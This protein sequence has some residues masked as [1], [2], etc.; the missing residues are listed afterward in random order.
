[1]NES[2]GRGKGDSERQSKATHMV[3]HGAKQQVVE[4]HQ[5]RAKQIEP[6]TSG[7]YMRPG[8]DEIPLFLVE[9]WYLKDGRLRTAKRGFVTR[10]AFLSLYGVLARMTRAML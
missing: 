6:C 4:G 5:R 2:G 9:A 10:F 7:K 8:F 3:Q 1:M